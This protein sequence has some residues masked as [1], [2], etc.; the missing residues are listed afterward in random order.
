MIREGAELG[1]EQ[2]LGAQKHVIGEWIRT[3]L[4]T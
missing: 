3:N 2:I 4:N 1:T